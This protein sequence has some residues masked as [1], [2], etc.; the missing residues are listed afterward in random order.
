MNR[1][2]AV[3]RLRK[4]ARAIESDAPMTEPL[5]P[6]RTLDV[7]IGY[8]PTSTLTDTSGR[9]PIVAIWRGRIDVDGPGVE[10]DL[11]GIGLP[12]DI[13]IGK[14]DLEAKS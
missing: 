3:R 1:T 10:I 7:S 9:V 4:I 12:P 8:A 13:A 6:A 5:P 2:K 11:R 14:I